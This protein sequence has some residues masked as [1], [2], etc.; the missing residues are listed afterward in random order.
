MRIE[1]LDIEQVEEYYRIGLPDG[2]W[3]LLFEGEVVLTTGDVERKTIV[4]VWIDPCG[5]VY[6]MDGTGKRRYSIRDVR[7]WYIEWYDEDSYA[8]CLVAD[9]VDMDEFWSRFKKF[10]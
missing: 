6:T 1:I 2:D 5:I 7:G 8:V 10:L 3:R 9:W 4:G